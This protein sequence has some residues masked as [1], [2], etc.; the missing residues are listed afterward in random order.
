MQ[1]VSTRGGNPASFDDVLLGGPAADGGLFLPS[2]WPRFSLAEIGELASVPYSE[3]AVRILLPFARGVLSAEELRDDATSAYAS[4]A[5]RAVAPLVQLAP[6]SFLLELFH[7]PTFAFK[8]LALQLMGRLFARLLAR[9][10]RRAT[11]IAATSGDTGSAAIAAFRGQPGLQVI[12]LHPKGRVSE[13]QRRQMTTVADANVHNIALDGDFDDAQ[14]VVKQ[15]FG[16][17]EFSR[18]MNLAAVNSINLVRILTQSVYYFTAAAALG[19][20]CGRAVNFVV[21]TGNFGDVFA[22]EAAARMGL[23]VG[24]L[25]IATNVNDILVRA[26]STGEYGVAGAVQTTF[27]PSMDIQVA[28]NFERALFEGSGRDSSW[29]RRAM[30]EFGSS[31]RLPIPE[32]IRGNLRQHYIAEKTGERD[33]LDAIRRA[34]RDTGIIVDPH[35]GVGLGAYARVREQLSGPVV[36]LATAHPAKFP[37][38]ILQAIGILPQVPEALA[39]LSGLEEHCTV[40][41]NSV[42]AVQ[43][44]ILERTR[45]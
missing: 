44:F 22:G 5:N 7:G 13:M 11:I 18:R 33:T 3:A 32:N 2:E 15:L 24:R 38:A 9:R 35:T 26:F 31:R 23:P 4:F 37:E 6:D 36:A 34:W 45:A 12:V 21:P 20:E 25:V 16:D 39:K 19:A 40:L 42:S 10:G 41:P 29:V 27:S 17:A 28:S 14:T 8:D 1:F 30:M 43:S